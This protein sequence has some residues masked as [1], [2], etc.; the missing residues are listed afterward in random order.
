MPTPS[1]LNEMWFTEV[2]NKREFDRIP[3]FMSEDGVAQ[4]FGIDSVPVYGP[5]E[6]RAQMEASVARHPDIE[7]EVVRSIHIENTSMV[8]WRCTTTGDDG[9]VH[10]VD[11]LSMCDW[12][13]GKIIRGVN[14]FDPARFPSRSQN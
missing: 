8:H 9:E 5:E 4:D 7:F 3:E 11:G 10:H 12:K 13:D 14:G 2:W 6:T 1:E